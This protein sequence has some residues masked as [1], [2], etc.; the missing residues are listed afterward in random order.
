[1]TTDDDV[2]RLSGALTELEGSISGVEVVTSTLRTEMTKADRAIRDTSGNTRALSRSIGSSLRSAFD[3]L[4][5]EGG[6]VSD[7]LRGVGRSLSGTVL[8]QA[9]KPVQSA[10]GG[11]ISNG[12]TAAF[13]GSLFA[14][15]AAFSGGRVQAFARGGVVERATAFPMRGGTGLMGEAGPEAIMPLA[16]GPDGA[17]GVRAAGGG[18]RSV[19]VVM[20]IS[21]PDAQSFRRSQGQI[22]AELS[23]AIGRGERNL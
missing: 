19:Q 16:R 23:R 15:G 7:V 5:F 1:M 20:N 6:R 10:V 18:G 12:L 2:E 22:A 3:D 21:T 11:A 17:L 13:A 14:D 4:V 9:L 8:D